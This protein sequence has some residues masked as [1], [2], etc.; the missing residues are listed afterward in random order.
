MMIVNHTGF[1]GGFILWE[2][3]VNGKTESPAM[4]SI[5]APTHRGS[6]DIRTTCEMTTKSPWTHLPVAMLWLLLSAVVSAV[7][8]PPE[9][10]AD[11]YLLDA[12]R[13]IEE[14]DFEGAKTAMDRILELQTQHDLEL[15]EEFPFRYAEVLARLELYDEAVE[16]VTQ[17]LMLTGRDGEHYRAALELLSD[18]EAAMAEAEAAAA[19]AA[20]AETRQPG[21]MREFDGMEFVWIP[22]GDFRMGSARGNEKPVTRV[23]ISRGYWLGRYEVTQ[24]AWQAVVGTA[25]SWFSGCGECPVENVSWHDAQEFIDT[26]NARS[27]GAGYRLPTE[28]EWEYA[29][30]AGTSGEAAWEQA[31]RTRD[32]WEGHAASLDA[33]AWYEDNSGG[34]THPVGQ[35]EPNAWELHDMRGNVYEWV[36]DWDGDYPGGS[37]TDPRGPASPEYRHP[38]G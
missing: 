21:D 16:L 9:I 28:A 35:K 38:S 17:Y 29:A 27:R 37:V 5:V 24:A 18:A 19:A 1:P 6:V 10:Q 33:I 36:Q 23:R 11:R 3:G 15:P 4:P 31:A 32:N 12:E 7:Q 25:P 8:L 13:A 30:R 34:R 2:D 20:E 26:L 14:Q 22:A